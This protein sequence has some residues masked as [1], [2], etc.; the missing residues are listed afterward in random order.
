MG[1]KSW[2]LKCWLS[3]AMKDLIAGSDFEARVISSMKT[4]RIIVIPSLA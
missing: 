1:P 2:I 4:G 3:W